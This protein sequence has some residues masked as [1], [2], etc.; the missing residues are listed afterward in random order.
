MKIS[1]KSFKEYNSHRSITDNESYNYPICMAPW[2]SLIF[3]LNGEMTPCCYNKHYNWGK[4]HTGINYFDLWSNKHFTNLRTKIAN[5]D[6]SYGCMV[7]YNSL[8]NREYNNVFAKRYDESKEMM[9]SVS[10]TSLEFQLSNTCNFSCIMCNEE[11]SSSICD[12]FGNHKKNNYYD[13]SFAQ[14]L[15]SIL[16]NIK[17]ISFSGGEPFLIKQ[18][19]EI[20]DLSM[21][22][23]DNPLYIFS[24]NGSHIKEKH[25]RLFEEKKSLISM[26]FDS[27]DKDIFNKITGSNDFELVQ[28]NLLRIKQ[29]LEAKGENCN[30]KIC[31]MRQNIFVFHDTFTYLNDLNIKISLNHVCFPPQCAIQEMSSLE[32]SGI[33]VKLRNASIRTDTP[34]QK[35][36]FIVYLGFIKLIEN[37]IFNSLKRER[38]TYNL[39]HY[40]RLFIKTYGEYFKLIETKEIRSAKDLYE[41]LFSEINDTKTKIKVVEYFTSIPSFLIMSEINM[42][43]FNYLTIKSRVMQAVSFF[44]IT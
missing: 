13:D 2:Y 1:K 27:I 20:L 5:R 32:L 41:Y 11:Y 44:E 24:T 33:I 35:Q 16:P 36:N 15:I 23:C 25:F 31:T 38:E 10:P 6:F 37:Y 18:C 12:F 8:K 29:I 43:N 39:S 14:S 3:T 22:Y 19:D 28:E 42:Y 34:I 40:R 17:K 7:C 4:Y 26:S 30:V 21:K 9:S